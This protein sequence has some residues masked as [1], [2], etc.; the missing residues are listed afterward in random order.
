MDATGDR[1][2]D[3]WG[4]RTPYEPGTA[5]ATRTGIRLREGV[6]EDEVERWV[7]SVSQ[8]HSNG[9]G[10]DIA[11]RDGRIAGV[12]GRAVDRVG[13]GR[14]GPKDRYGRQAGASPDR[15]TRPMVREAGRLVECDGEHAMSRVVARTPSPRTTCPG[16][17]SSRPH[18]PPATTTMI[19][20]LSSQLLITVGVGKG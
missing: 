17:C 9:D 3:P 1:I 8:P 6:G 20:N 13:R 10:R 14:P 7:P 18:R 4:E 12:R 2:A 11:V 5:W 15:V 16:R 19:K